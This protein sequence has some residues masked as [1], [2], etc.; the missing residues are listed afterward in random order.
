M[1]GWPTIRVSSTSWTAERVRCTRRRAR[2]ILQIV[3]LL[4]DQGADPLLAN[5]D[6]KTP[7][8]LAVEKGNAEV[9]EMLR[10]AGRPPA[11]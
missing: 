1:R 10:I 11:N 2:T 3:R 6:G 7:L 9:A 8:D 5:G 4:L